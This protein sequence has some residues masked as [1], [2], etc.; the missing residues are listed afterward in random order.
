MLY[1]GKQYC[2]ITIYCKYSNIISISQQYI[3]DHPWSLLPITATATLL[4][5]GRYLDAEECRATTATTTIFPMKFTLEKQI[6]NAL[7]ND[8][9]SHPTFFQKNMKILFKSSL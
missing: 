3:V 1:P 2:N 7:Q 5:V 9:E 8:F 4:L 6:K